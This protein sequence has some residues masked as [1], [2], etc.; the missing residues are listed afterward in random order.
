MSNG[1]GAGV[2][3]YIEK[4]IEEEGG[5]APGTRSQDKEADHLALFFDS[6]TT[7]DDHYLFIFI[8]TIA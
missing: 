8:G 1:G 7:A 5:A 4:E 3:Y 6:Y 2:P